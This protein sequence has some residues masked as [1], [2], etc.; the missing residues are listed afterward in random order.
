MLI[1]SPKVVYLPFIVRDS[2]QQLRVGLLSRQELVHDLLNIGQASG[3]ADLLK[4]VLDLKSSLHLPLH[5]L[6]KELTPHLLHHVVLLHLQLVRVLVLVCSGL[7]DL[8]LARHAVHATLQGLLLV[9]NGFVQGFDA[10]LTMTLLL[11]DEVHQGL[12]LFFGL[13]THLLRFTT[14]F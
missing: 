9:L 5:L 6:L 12:K 11:I 13:E 3:C 1:L 14:L 7:R 2:H 8:L 4:S 10:L